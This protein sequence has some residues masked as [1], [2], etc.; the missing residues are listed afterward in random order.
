MKLK[1]EIKQFIK[2]NLHLIDMDDWN[3]FWGLVDN[4]AGMI[5]E[6][7]RDVKD[8]TEFLLACGCDTLRGCKVIP[9]GYLCC[10]DRSEI[11]IPEN[12]NRI[13]FGAFC[14]M[15]NLT[16]VTIPATVEVVQEEAFYECTNLKEVTILNPNIQLSTETFLECSSL[17]LIKYNGTKKQFDSC[18]DDV[19]PLNEGCLVITTEGPIQL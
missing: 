10:S 18:F 11:K 15:V 8:L 14:G 7:M 6:D 4:D 12:I 1:P 2:D 17:T 16:Q 19:A 9:E 5:F 3:T 13:G